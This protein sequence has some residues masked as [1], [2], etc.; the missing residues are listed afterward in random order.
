MLEVFVAAQLASSVAPHVAR[1]FGSELLPQRL[2]R[3]F[4]LPVS[5][6]F[7]NSGST[8]FK[9]T[10]WFG[11]HSDDR[12]HLAYAEVQVHT[13]GFR[14]PLPRSLALSRQLL[15]KGIVELGGAFGG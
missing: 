11:Q 14:V 2:R 10:Q 15:H 9:N 1:G 6:T 5:Q 8:R 12:L 13:C 4:H 7:Q 3:L